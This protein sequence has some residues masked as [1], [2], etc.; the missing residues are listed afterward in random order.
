L[1]GEVNLRWRFFKNA[2]SN[3]TWVEYGLRFGVDSQ[4][5]DLNVKRQ[6]GDYIVSADCVD[7]WPDPQEPKAAD[8]VGIDVILWIEGRDSAGWSIDGGGP[9]DAGGVSSIWSTDSAHNSQYRLVHQ[10]ATFVVT[11]VRM[12]PKSPQVDD[13]PILEISIKNTGTMDGN[14]TLEVQ[15]VTD[16]SFPVTELTY[17]TDIIQQSKTDNIFITL[18]RFT[19]PTTGMY[20]LIV[21][22]DSNE[23]LWNGSESSKDF[24]VAVK[25]EDGGLLAGS[26]MLIVI[27]LAALILIL[28]VAV[29]VLVKRDSGDGTYEYEYNEGDVKEYV[30]IPAAI[31]PSPDAATA[32]PV[33]PLMAQAL[34]EFPQW[35]QATIQGYFDQGWDIPSLHDWVNSNK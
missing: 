2:D 19:T 8:M 29:V 9:N 12:D 4:S 18:E 22:A 32:A 5:A 26:G 24:N 20:F 15:S 27:G 10:E 13:T 7:L 1:A 11:D 3:L 6:G 35:D 21:D 34:Q 23:V 28:L 17:T 16:G 30:D 25:G 33:D 14:L 31:G